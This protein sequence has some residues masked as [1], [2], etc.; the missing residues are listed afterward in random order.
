[1]L[2]LFVLIGKQCVR[3][4][5]VL[6]AVVQVAKLFPSGK[7]PEGQIMDQPGDFNTFRTTR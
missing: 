3:E 1:M 4:T 2:A 5:A 6:I 7:F